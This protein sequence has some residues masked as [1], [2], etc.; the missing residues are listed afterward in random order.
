MLTDDVVLRVGEFGG[1]FAVAPS[2]HLFSRLVLNGSYEPELVE[3]F[4]S[5]VRPK[6]DVIDVGANIGFF[7]VIAG[8][9]LTEGRVLAIEPTPGAFARLQYNVERNGIS[10]R[11]ILFNGLASSQSGE[12]SFYSVDGKEEYS[13]MGEL[14]HPS[15]AGEPSKLQK[16]QARTLDDLVEAHGLKPSVV[17]VDVEGGEALVFAGAR[18]VLEHHRP[19]VISELSN[20]LLASLGS[21][22]PEVVRTFRD[23]GYRVVD[24]MDPRAEPG[25][26]DYGDILC[27][28]EA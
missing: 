5:H 1:D 21:S 25:T 17:K 28:P 15:I 23:F 12:T 10:D 3:L 11:T 22:G 4:R 27:L 8:K 7:T 20:V 16:A 24:P 26:K 6:K 14:R 13:S 18:R 9:L 2:S 19:V